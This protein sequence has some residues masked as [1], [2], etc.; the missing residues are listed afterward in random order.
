MFSINAFSETAPAGFQ[1]YFLLALALVGLE[2]LSGYAIKTIF[3]SE[4]SSFS[5]SLRDFDA[6]NNLVLLLYLS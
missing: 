6:L 3:V 5:T 2:S 1:C 4:D